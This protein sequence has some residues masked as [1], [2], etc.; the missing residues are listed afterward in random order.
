[1]TRLEVPAFILAFL[2]T[3]LGRRAK[4]HSRRNRFDCMDVAAM[5]GWYAPKAP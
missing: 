4:G 3:G 2:L 1:M 5:P